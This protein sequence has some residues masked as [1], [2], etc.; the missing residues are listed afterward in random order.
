MTKMIKKYFLLVTSLILLVLCPIQAQE[1]APP[2]EGRTT[3]PERFNTISEATYLN[4]LLL[5]GFSLE[6]Q[7]FYIES[8]D[9]T[10]VFADHHSDV[11]FNPASVI[12][13]ATSFV[14]LD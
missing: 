4:Q 7:G 11:A 5:R 6:T 8:L 10:K 2:A 13:I 12:K 14:A 1:L 9:G 3:A